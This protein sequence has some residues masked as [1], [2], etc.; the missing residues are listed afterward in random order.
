MGNLRLPRD[1]FIL[2]LSRFVFFLIAI[3]FYLIVA[4]GEQNQLVLDVQPN[5]KA[6]GN[7]A[8]IDNFAQF[9]MV[10]RF[11]SN[12]VQELPQSPDMGQRQLIDVAI[13]IGIDSS[14][15]MKR[16]R[17]SGGGLNL[18]KEALGVAL[19]GLESLRWEQIEPHLSYKRLALSY[20]NWAEKEQ[21]RVLVNWVIVSSQRD[22]DHF[23][24]LVR[25][26]KEIQVGKGFD[27]VFAS[28]PERYADWVDHL[29]V[30]GTDTVPAMNFAWELII[31]QLEKSQ[32]VRP[33]GKALL[34]MTDGLAED[35]EEAI[36]ES[37][38]W[39][40]DMAYSS[41]FLLFPEMQT[42]DVY[43]DKFQVGPGSSAEFLSVDNFKKSF[44]KLI[45]VKVN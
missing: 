34:F 24:E 5:S 6:S 36:E 7:T 8:E 32:R 31:N 43:R 45:S 18:Y 16:M 40:R 44:E 1:R 23:V 13:V 26:V 15:S 11:G 19:G 21:N 28:R 30:G 17:P 2:S 29:L 14:K 12:V 10:P 38:S 25:A 9:F 22:L 39:S 33:N 37:N 35:S 20:I 41:S 27:E 42:L 3:G 4:R